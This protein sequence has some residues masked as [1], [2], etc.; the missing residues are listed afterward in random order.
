[1]LDNI[2]KKII[3]ILFL[4]GD[5]IDLVHLKKISNLPLDYYIDIAKIKTSLNNIGLDLICDGKNI[6]I[7]TSSDF[8]DILQIQI[9]FF[10]KI[11]NKN[12][13]TVHILSDKHIT[14]DYNVIIYDVPIINFTT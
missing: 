9:D 13:Y 10:S 1:M 3:N 11:I 6:N 8:F 12:K 7:S 4:S 5:E 14:C 2:E